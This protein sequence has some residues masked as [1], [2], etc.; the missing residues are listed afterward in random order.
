MKN[1]VFIVLCSIFFATFQ[2]K[3]GEYLGLYQNI[4]EYMS[5]QKV[6]LFL[7]PEI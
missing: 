4:T 7:V 2:I 5:C 6:D 3:A 1:G